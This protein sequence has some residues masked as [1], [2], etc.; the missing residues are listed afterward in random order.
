MSDPYQS[1]VV[2][3]HP[4]LGLGD[5]FQLLPRL[6]EKEEEE[7]KVEDKLEVVGRKM[8]KKAGK[9]K[10]IFGHLNLLLQT[11]VDDTWGGHLMV[12]CGAGVRTRLEGQ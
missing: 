9:G 5:V 10:M 12:I 11:V 1:F 7:R 6:Q 4:D 2:R 8:G 3:V